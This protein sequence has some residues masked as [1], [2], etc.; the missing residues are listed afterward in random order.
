MLE[1][2]VGALSPGLFKKLQWIG[3]SFYGCPRGH[4]HDSCMCSEI[5]QAYPPSN[6]FVCVGDGQLYVPDVIILRTAVQKGADVN[7]SA[8]GF[9]KSSAKIILNNWP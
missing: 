7:T 8:P 2:L 6:L 3:Y 1:T 5:V 9:G 4:G